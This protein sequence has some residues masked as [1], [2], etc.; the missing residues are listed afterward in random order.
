MDEAAKTFFGMAIDPLHI[1]TGGY[2]LGRVDN[3]IVRDPGTDLPKVPGSSISGVC[4][5]YAI[6]GLKGNEKDKAI[7]CATLEDKKSKNNCGNC[8]I[9]KTFGFASGTKKS[10]QMGLVKFFDAGLVAFPVATMCGPV[11]VTT[12][13]VLRDL[14]NEAVEALAEDKLLTSF[15]VTGGR[16]NLGWL[17]LPCQKISVSL[18]SAAGNSAQMA[19]VNDRLVVAPEYLF[20]EIV[21]TNLEV[22]TS[23]SIDFETGAAKDGALFTYE[24]IP[25]ATLLAFDVVVDDYRCKADHTAGKVWEIIRAGLSRFE[26]LGLGGMN[27]RG[28]GRMKV[29][30]LSSDQAV[31]KG[32]KNGR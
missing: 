11:W 16:L 9:C 27:T 4:R 8:V 17:Y 13:S 32:D 12:P 6:Y 2:R 21:N 15:D 26:I 31:T 18:P 7:G 20:S 1:G 10:S 30:N 22:R 23:V 28:F 5:N 3:T 29:V 24:A 19:R 25:R 14:G